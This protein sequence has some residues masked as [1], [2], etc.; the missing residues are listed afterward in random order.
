MSSGIDPSL[1]PDSQDP[2]SILG[3]S[4]GSSFEEVQKARDQRLEEVGDDP[5]AKARIEA[6]YDAVLMNSLKERQLGKI[7]SA[8]VSASEQEQVNSRKSSFN[9]PL[10][11]KFPQKKDQTSIQSGSNS[12]S[13]LPS[14]EMP[15][16]TELVVKIS[17]GLLLLLLLFISNSSSVDL[18]LSTS[19]I[20]TLISQIRRRRPWLSSLGWSVVL[21]STGLIIGGLLANYSSDFLVGN[22]SLD[23]DQVEAIPAIIL[24][25]IGA[26]LFV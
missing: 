8:A 10:N 7:S 25:W 16:G 4:Q 23:H 2:Y 26:L 5:Q 24:L 12:S 3:L 21:L 20:G 6:S 1:N 9:I 18:L 17:L 22:I 13:L 19:L 11:F 14:L 15:E